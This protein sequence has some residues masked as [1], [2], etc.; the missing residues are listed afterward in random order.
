MGI[1]LKV[2]GIFWGGLGVANMVMTK[3]SDE[4]MGF[5]IIFNFLLFVFPAIIVFF[6]GTRSSK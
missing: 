3:G 5:S 1:F 4:L 6:I 2:L